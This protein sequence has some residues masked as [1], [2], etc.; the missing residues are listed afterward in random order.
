MKLLFET[1]INKSFLE[2]K[3]KFNQDLFMAL[4]PPLVNLDIKRFNGC[5]V[6]DEIHLDIGSF[7]LKQ[8]WVCVI[9]EENQSDKEWSFVD[10]GRIMPWPLASWRHH[11]RVI[12]LN[13][14]TS[15]IVD[16]ISYRCT[17]SWLSGIIYPA[18]WLSFASRP[19]CYKN[20]F[21]GE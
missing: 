10:E 13:K 14:D 12:Q 4:K 11:H 19:K 8:K 18:M 5:S 3:S 2:I 20:F 6:K 1:K 9:T 17:P 16:D 15:L 21:K 7:G